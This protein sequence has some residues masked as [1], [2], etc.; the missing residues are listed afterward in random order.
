MTSQNVFIGL[1]VDIK[2]WKVFI[3]LQYEE[4]FVSNKVL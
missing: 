4:L 3:V 2:T 1:N